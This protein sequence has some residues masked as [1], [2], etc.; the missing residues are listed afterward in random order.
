MGLKTVCWAMGGALL[1]MAVALGDEGT[2][3]KPNQGTPAWQRMLQ[4]DDAKKAKKLLG[5]IDEWITAKKW[6]DAAR[7]AEEL[8]AFREAKQGK[9][10]WQAVSAR[11]EVAAIEKVQA[12]PEQKRNA[13]AENLAVRK[14][15][16]QMEAKGK[17]AAAEPMRRKLLDLRRDVL[18]EEHP[19]TARSY[20]NLAMNQN[21]QGRYKEAE[22][23]YRTA[24]AIC[25]KVHGENHPDTATSYNNVAD[26]K[27]TRLNSSHSS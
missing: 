15:A 21:A 23:G 5:Q 26:R 27:S 13:Y 1:L 18:G 25:R 19:H 14:Q 20:N 3:A 17:H 9:E 6:A 16:A 8:A 22:Q 4:G 10:H 24:L 11:F 7:V 2:K 12:A